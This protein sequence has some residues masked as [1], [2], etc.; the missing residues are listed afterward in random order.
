MADASNA[1]DYYNSFSKN[2]KQKNNYTIKYNYSTPK[3]YRKPKYY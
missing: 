1:K 2:K 3:S